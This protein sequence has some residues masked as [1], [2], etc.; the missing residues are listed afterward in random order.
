M[1]F[2]LARME[3]SHLVIV[4]YIRKAMI[5]RGAS[6]CHV[7]KIIAAIH[8]IDVITDGYHIW[9]G[10]IPILRANAR[11]NRIIKVEGDWIED[12]NHCDILNINKILDPIAWARKYLTAASVS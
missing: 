3:I 12:R 11:V 5:I 2:I 9:Q 8:E 4:V 7:D 1:A 10:A 6:F